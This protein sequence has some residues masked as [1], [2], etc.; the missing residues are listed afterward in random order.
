MVVEPQFKGPVHS[1]FNGGLL[2]TAHLA[3]PEARTVFFGEREQVH[4]VRDAVGHLAPD[5]APDVEWRVIR[6]PGALRRIGRVRRALAEAGCFLRALGRARRRRARL[7]LF[8]SLPRLGAATLKLFAR[9]VCP[10]T[11]IL[12]VVHDIGALLPSAG[13][14]RTAAAR[15]YHRLL[16]LAPP[17]NLR[18]V[19]PTL[20]AHRELATADP[21]LARQFTPLPL[22][23]PWQRESAAVPGTRPR[24]ALRFG[25]IGGGSRERLEPFCRLA[26][27]LK[28][29][30][31]AAEFILAGHLTGAARELGEDLAV[32]DDAPEEPLV[33][34]RLARSIDT[35]DYA[36][37]I[38]TS[39]TY[40]WRLSASFL[41]AL[42]HV[43]PS[44]ALA[45]PYSSFL[46]ETMGDIGYLCTDYD[47]LLTAATGLLEE[48]P[49]GRY[50]R[51]CANIL[52]QRARLAPQRVAEELARAALELKSG[53]AHRVRARGTA[54]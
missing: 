27:D 39:G 25:L 35:L 4:W 48:F 20:L 17:A 41:D 26:R 11:A 12:A 49:A 52:E 36:V 38:G 28:S 43:K 8:C 19:A 45:T 15:L 34:D 7:V 21:A 50:R 5:P 14:R 6:V 31:P 22:P 46:F 44:L 9:W 40:R 18:F 47:A 13:G 1:S 10:R 30:F 32:L 23:Y 29:R 42:S 53:S 33:L 3:F 51:Q 2:L 24:G 16:R 54:A 37:W